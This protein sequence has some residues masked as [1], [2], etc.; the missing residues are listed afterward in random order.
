MFDSRSRRF[1]AIT[2]VLRMAAMLGTPFGEMSARR[3]V[4]LGKGQRWKPHQGANEIARRRRQI[5]E[6]MLTVS[7]GL[8][9]T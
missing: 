7:N 8:V 5:E 4:P 1:A 3:I 9:L 2:A 6:G